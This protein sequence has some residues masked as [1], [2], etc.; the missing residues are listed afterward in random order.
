MREATHEKL[1]PEKYEFV[2][3]WMPEVAMSCRYQFL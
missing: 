3:S 1:G 2:P